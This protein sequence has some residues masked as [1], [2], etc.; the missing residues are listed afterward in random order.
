MRCDSYT[1]SEPQWNPYAAPAPGQPSPHRGRPLPPLPPPP[2]W[3]SP[4]LSNAGQPM[5]VQ[6]TFGHSGYDRSPFEQSAF[7][8]PATPM[9]APARP[10]P[11][12]GLGIALLVLSGVVLL[13]DILRAVTAPAAIRAYDLAHAEGR[14]PAAVVTAHGIVG[15]LSLMALLPTWIVGSLWLS[16]AHRNAALIN[17]GWLR[18]SAVW[19][20]LGWW[21][22]IVFWVFPKQVVDD[23]WKI[24]SGVLENG[25]PRSRYRRTSVWW[26]LWCV[27]AL[28]S[29]VAHRL[30]LAHGPIDGHV[31]RGVIIGL[32]FAAAIAGILAFAAWVPIVLGVSRAQ[33]ELAAEAGSEHP[34]AY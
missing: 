28:L 31:Y 33:T 3:E 27:Y 24:T 29:R 8:P 19:A 22:P 13:C 7:G 2:P 10:R 6:T 15:L 23:S 12:E 20:W 18:R 14:D 34:Q 17:P 32:G 1:V 11:N 4:A 25:S 16:R 21:V 30:P 9:S 5:P 26:G